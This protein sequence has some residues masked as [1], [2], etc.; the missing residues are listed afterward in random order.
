MPERL[1]EREEVL[2]VA[3]FFNQRQ[4]TMNNA[5]APRVKMYK[6][7]YFFALIRDCTP[8]T[9]LVVTVVSTVDV[10]LE[11]CTRLYTELRSITVLRTPVVA[12]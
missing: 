10:E 9:F 3:H 11:Y 1:S 5:H 2:N 8:S 4:A 12:L 6:Y 7:A